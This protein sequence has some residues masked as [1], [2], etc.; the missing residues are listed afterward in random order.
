MH[1]NILEWEK[2][3]TPK[4]KWSEQL[5]TPKTMEWAV[6]HFKKCDIFGVDFK[7]TP[8]FLE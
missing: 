6:V 7:C 8:N 2:V 1:S 4:K 3:S 5:S